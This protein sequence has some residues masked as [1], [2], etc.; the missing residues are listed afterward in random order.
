MGAAARIT[1]AKVDAAI[2]STS[3]SI[4]R[5]NLLPRF[6]C[7]RV[8]SHPITIRSTNEIRPY[9]HM[10]GRSNLYARQRLSQSAEQVSHVVHPHRQPDQ[11]VLQSDSDAT[12]ARDGGVGHGGA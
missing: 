5:I 9:G 1:T 2:E 3:S 11:R 7:V 12:L 4:H 6:S 10:A 8:A